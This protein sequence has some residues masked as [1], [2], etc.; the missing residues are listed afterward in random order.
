MEVFQLSGRLSWV[1]QTEGSLITITG[2]VHHTRRGRV[3]TRDLKHVQ[4]G[5]DGMKIR[6]V[7]E[8]TAVDGKIPAPVGR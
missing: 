7:F 1:S 5:N 4:K 2:H 8:G 6:A 3:G